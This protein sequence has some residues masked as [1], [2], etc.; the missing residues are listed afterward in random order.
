VNVGEILQRSASWLRSKGLESPRL[1]AEL[2]LAHVLQSDRVRLY[3]E[4]DRP[5]EPPEVDAYR[6]L[7]R[8]R[9][10]G[11]PVAYLTGAR[12]FYGL[13]FAV[14]SD[15]LVP[16]PETELLVDR[17]RELAPATVLEIGTGSGCIAIALARYLS[18]ARIVATDVS[19]AALGVATD[20][21]EAHEAADRIEFREGDLFAPVDGETFDLVVCNPPYVADGGADEDVARH[22]PHVALF[23]GADGCD[24]IRR[25]VAEAPAHLAPG[26][27]LLVEIGEEQGDAVRAL[28]AEHFANVTIHP[29]LA[30]R[31]RVLEAR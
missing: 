7:L 16:R 30:G 15:V 11:E 22:E 27:T 13:T 6:D 29:D 20:N 23:S 12:E 14:T 26:G 1:E 9:A 24:L 18:D 31:A 17:A 2:L 25:L 3:M 10:R 21:A 4:T 5:L 19:A 8:R 28:A